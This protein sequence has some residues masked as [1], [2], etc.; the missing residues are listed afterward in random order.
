M[1]NMNKNVDLMNFIIKK[2]LKALK[3][4]NLETLN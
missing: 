3:E 4:E 1:I 2:I